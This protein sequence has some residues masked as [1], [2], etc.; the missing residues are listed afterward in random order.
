ML[1]CSVYVRALIIIEIK[2]SLSF[3]QNLNLDGVLKIFSCY[4]LYLL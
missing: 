3:L 2:L 1:A 4:I